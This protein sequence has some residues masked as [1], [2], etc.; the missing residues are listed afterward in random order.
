VI[1]RTGPGNFAASF[2]VPL[3]LVAG[4]ASSRPANTTGATQ[5]VAAH[6]IPADSPLAPCIDPSPTRPRPLEAAIAQNFGDERLQRAFSL[7]DGLFRAIPASATARPT[8]SASMAFCNLLAGATA[9]NVRVFDAARA[10]GLS[11][12]LAVVTIADS[13]LH[14]GPRSYLV[15]GGTQTESLQRYDA[16]LA[17][18]AVIAPDSMSSCPAMRASSSSA[19]TAAR[20]DLPGYQVLAID[21]D[22]GAAGIVYSARTNGPCGSTTVQ[23]ASVAPA[24]EFVSVPWTMVTRGADPQS[25]TISYQPRPCDL[26]TFGLFD[27]TKQPAV[28]ADRSNPALVTVELARVLTTCGA[29]EPTHLLLRSTT[30]ATDLPENLVHAAVGAVDVQE[31][32]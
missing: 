19:P 6:T 8:I 12:G 11:F 17:W 32:G 9:T 3:L 23:P 29:A 21:A 22:T 13:I 20:G 16:R 4:C 31:G 28:W 2:V 26:R 1:L 7:D 10:H 18:I 5:S 14:T 24:V 30:R 25:A 27:E 15:D